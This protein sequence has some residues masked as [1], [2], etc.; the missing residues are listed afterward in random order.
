M[1]WIGFG[2]DGKKK[3]HV[4]DL[5]GFADADGDEGLSAESLNGERDATGDIADGSVGFE[6]PHHSSLGR[7][8][9][10]ETQEAASKVEAGRERGRRR[11]GFVR[12]WSCVRWA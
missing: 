4:V 9:S 11:R 7:E 5:P 2:L 12:V 6:D 1:N 8:S 10:T 3:A